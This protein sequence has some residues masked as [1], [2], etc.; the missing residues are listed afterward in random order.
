MKS[1]QRHRAESR[2]TGW[3]LCLSPCVITQ[4]DVQMLFHNNQV[5]VFVCTIVK[6]AALYWP[7]SLWETVSA[8]RN[9]FP[10]HRPCVT[11]NLRGE[12]RTHVAA[13]KVLC[14]KFPE[15]AARFAETLGEEMAALLLDL[16][17]EERSVFAEER[18]SK[19]FREC[20]KNARLNIKS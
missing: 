18:P 17:M 16:P 14:T 12:R 2:T 9:L 20:E 19:H 4:E 6:L 13:H 5:C 7:K 11:V 10:E 3:L 15:N 1:W 8:D